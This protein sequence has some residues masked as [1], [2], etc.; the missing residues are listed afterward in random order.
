MEQTKEETIEI[1]GIP[2]ETEPQPQPEEKKEPTKLD[3]LIQ[4]LQAFSTEEEAK[5]NI[6][7][8]TLELHCARSMGYKAIR[9]IKDAGGFRAQPTQRHPAKEATAKIETPK[10]ETLEP[11]SEEE[12]T[13]TELAEGQPVE[14]QPVTPKTFPLTPEKLAETLEIFFKR[15]AVLTDYPEFALEPKE[16]KSLGEA[17]IPVIEMYIPQMATNPIVW[18][19]IATAIVFAPKTLGFI[20]KRREKQ[21]KKQ[22]DEKPLPKAPEPP[23][24]DPPAEAPKATEKTFLSTLS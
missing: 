6:S 20:I 10:E 3:Q 13:E 8:I 2:P 19:A 14:G 24:T 16:S 4:R 23:K 1:T 17:W 15:I 12:Y 18:A 22:E 11:Q 21:A 7:K 9:K 5:A